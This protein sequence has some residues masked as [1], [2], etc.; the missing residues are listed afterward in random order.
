MVRLATNVTDPIAD[1]LTRIRNA[2]LSF[3]DELH[4]PASNMN[5]ALVRI[6]ER[7]GYI[8]GFEPDGEGV[9]RSIKVQLKY[10]RDRQRTITGLRRISKPGRRVYVKRDSL[11]RVM[12]GLGVAILS[13]SKGLMTDREAARAGLGGEVLAYVW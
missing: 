5:E 1:A 6:L 13:T 7:E 4:V 8:E 9:D 11:P 10:G 3:K 12:G 2:N